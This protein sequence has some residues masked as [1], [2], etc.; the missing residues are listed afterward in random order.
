MLTKN[1]YKFLAAAGGSKG[2]SGVV[3]GKGETKTAY[4]ASSSGVAAQFFKYLYRVN[5]TDG[6]GVWLGTGK[7][8]ATSDDYALESRI[9]SGV[10]ISNPSD[11][12]LTLNDDGVHLSA[13]YGIGNTNSAPVEI[14]EIGLTSELKIGTSTVDVFLIERTVLENP[15]VIPVGESRQVT[16]TISFRYPK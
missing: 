11:Y 3:S 15:V 7:T 1:F 4:S 9:T 12:S 14:S 2:I 6:A 13:T 10:T 16:Y 8:P 5:L